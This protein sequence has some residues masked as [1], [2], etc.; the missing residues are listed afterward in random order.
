LV[1]VETGNKVIACC[2]FGKDSLA[3][4]I[5]QC[6]F[7]G[8]ENIDEVIYCKVMFNKTVS[9]EFPEHEKWIH[10][11]AIPLLKEKF[12]LKTTIVQA[13]F[14]YVDYFYR[15]RQKGKFVG[16]IVGFP[17]TTGQWCND[18]LKLNPMRKYLK[19]LGPVEEVVGIAA[20]ETERIRKATVERKILPLAEYG[21]TEAEAFEICKKYDLLSP[22]YSKGRRRL[23]CWF[24][25]FQR[26]GELRRLR[27][28]HPE[29]WSKLLLLDLVSPV[30]FR[31]KRSL[32]SFDYHFACEDYELSCRRTL[33]EFLEVV[34]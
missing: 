32:Q 22:A 23:G 24:C 1:D 8:I 11:H 6:N 34:V 7:S 29:L 25:H 26:V 18:R 19:S 30:S 17:M 28:E 4:I 9:A 3:A 14:S 33:D 21:I 31:P 20:D 13:P 27:S 10:N 12:G 2:S 5:T 15:T 16:N